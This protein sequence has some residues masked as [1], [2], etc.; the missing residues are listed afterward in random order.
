[1]GPAEFM[2]GIAWMAVCL[3]VLL[4]Q[5]VSSDAGVKRS[6]DA[7]A[8][9]VVLVTTLGLAFRRRFPIT[10]AAVV[11]PVSIYGSLRGYAVNITALGA[12]F[13]LGSAAYY[14]DRPRTVAIGLYAIAAILIGSLMTGGPLLSIQLLVSNVAAP[15]LAVAVG[16]ALRSR[17]DYAMRWRARAHEIEQLRDADQAR[18]MAQQRVQIAAEVHDVVG[19]R[20]AAITVQAR[21][22]GR[23]AS[24][25]DDSRVA[26]A[27]SEIDSLATAALAE[28]RR[29]V[30]Q[31]GEPGEVAPTHPVGA[32]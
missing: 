26:A 19:H 8:V 3:A 1:M 17:R 11:T 4:L 14:T 13:A 12:I 29:A 22:A 5:P 6:A 21:A 23:R 30:G 16:D 24:G 15:V 27:L 2:A 31:I 9:A 28:T 20:L 32:S 7:L 10:V 25:S 18:A